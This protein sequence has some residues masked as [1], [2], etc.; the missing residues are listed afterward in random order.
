MNFN[1]AI[2]VFIGVDKNLCTLNVPS[3]SKTAYE[4]AD[5]W[6]DFQNIVEIASPYKMPLEVTA[7]GLA[8]LLPQSVRDTLTYLSLT[9]T[10]DARDFRIMR[11]SLPVLANLDISSASIVGFNGNDGT[12]I[13]GTNNYEANT[14]PEF[15]FCNKD[16]V[17]KNSLVSI[18]FPTTITTIQ[19]C[20]FVRCNSLKLLNIPEGVTTIVDAAFSECAGLTN[21]NIP[22]SVSTIRDDAFRN[23]PGQIFV[24]EMNS[25]YSSLDGILFNEDKTYIIHCPIDK[26]GR[27]S[28]S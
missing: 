3:G 4:A 5:Q 8:A 13:R 11:D 15:A 12:S 9:G 17:G 23:S 26:T 14:I 27:Y 18:V 19:Y 2:D 16:W 21:I 24:N 1:Y 28:F 20:A 25:Q 7:G 10:I 22:S 6:K